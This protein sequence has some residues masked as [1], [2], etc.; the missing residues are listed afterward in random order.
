M[1]DW[2]DEGVILS[3]R[4]HGE[5]AALI[6]VFTA[7]HGR[8][9]GLVRGGAGR[10]LAPVLQ[11]GGQV[12]VVWKARIEDHL[13]TYTVEPI[14]SRAGLVMGD[15]I[16]L[17]GLSAVTALLAM[18]LPEREAHGALYDRTVALLDLLGQHEIWPLAYL[19]W[20]VALLAES[21]FALDLTTCAVTGAREGL[22]YVSPRTGRA[23]ARD[24]A[25]EWESRLL[26][27]PPVLRGEGDAGPDEIAA[28]LEV[29]G[30]F[31][32]NHVMR[33]LG[34]GALAPARARLIEALV[35]GGG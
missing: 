19:H 20:E 21:G 14:R 28:A 9:A 1:I 23:V 2:R 16:A 25:G 11:P 8:H 5:S 33:A 24:A 32:R 4:P 22:A 10:K 27:L 18:A 6:E 7:T 17:A 35:R 13:G 12:E 15:R 26:P 29:T 3:V 30:Y 34:E 31:L